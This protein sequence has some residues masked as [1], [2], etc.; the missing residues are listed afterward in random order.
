MAAKTTYLMNKV[1]DH[2]LRNSSYTPPAAVYLALWIGSPTVSGAG[3]AE[4]TGGSYVRIGIT[5]S[6]ASGGATANTVAITFPEATADWGTVTHAAV[7]DAVSAGN[8]LYFQALPASQV[9]STGVIAS[10]PIGDLDMT[11]T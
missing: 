6:A 5:F 1:I 9:I 2:V 8:V 3:G 10:V 11:E 7:C 4:V